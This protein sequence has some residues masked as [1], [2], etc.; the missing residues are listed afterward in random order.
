V[1]FSK[2]QAAMDGH[3][4]AKNATKMLLFNLIGTYNFDPLWNVTM[5][6]KVHGY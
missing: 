6:M 4:D 1:A 2:K 5:A 3:F